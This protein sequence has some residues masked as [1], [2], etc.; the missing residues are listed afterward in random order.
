L[1][2]LFEK[3]KCFSVHTHYAVE[4]L[5]ANS[6]NSPCVSCIVYAAEGTCELCVFLWVL[7]SALCPC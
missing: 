7:T 3:K 2:Q 4:Y 1:K 5:A 6:N